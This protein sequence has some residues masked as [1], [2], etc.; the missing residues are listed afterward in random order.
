MTRHWTRITDLDIF[1]STSGAKGASLALLTTQTRVSSGKTSGNTTKSRLLN[2]NHNICVPGT[3]IKPAA[4]NNRKT[5][6]DG[7]ARANRAGGRARVRP[8]DAML[9]VNQT[10][11][12]EWMLSFVPTADLAED[13]SRL[14]PFIRC[15]PSL[16]IRRTRWDGTLAEDR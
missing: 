13:A 9:S 6:S 2:N 10:V 8:D 11:R 14:I 15:Y 1:I 3:S 7:P 12:D 4:P 16:L 5:A